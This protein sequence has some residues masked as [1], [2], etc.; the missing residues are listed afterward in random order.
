[1]SFADRLNKKFKIILASGSPR[2]KE[3]MELAGLEFDIWPSEKE[4]TVTSSV[5]REICMELSR[6]KAEDVAASIRTYNDSH[7]DLVSPTDML[8][9]GADTIVALEDTVF[10][11]PKD[12]EDA[13]RM[14]KALSDHTHSVYTGV[15]LVF[16]SSGG[17]VGEHVFCEETKVTFCKLDEEDI[18]SYVATG[19]PLDKAGSYGVQTSSAVFVRSIEGD[20]YNVMGLPIARLMQELKMIVN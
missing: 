14:L 19:D 20:F 16:M 4:E 6:Q 13:K 11:K 3:L 8:I 10:G 12:E 18:D 5:P 15:T 9:I 1:M 17:R 7:P 2:R